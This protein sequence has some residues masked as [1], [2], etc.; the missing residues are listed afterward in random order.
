M[1]ALGSLALVATSAATASLLVLLSHVSTHPSERPLL[2]IYE[3]M[4][5]AIQNT[6][7]GIEVLFLDWNDREAVTLLRSF[8]GEAQRRQRLPLLTLEPFPDRAG[9]RTNA[10][11]DTL[12]PARCNVPQKVTGGTQRQ[13]VVTGDP[14]RRRIT[15]PGA[16]HHPQGTRRV[17]PRGVSAVSCT[18]APLRSSSVRCREG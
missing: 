17:R 6:P 10:A 4:P 9:G 15:G 2:G 11:E 13:C 7:L 14:R 3:P 1:R 18:V 8:L 5:T 16:R 12:R